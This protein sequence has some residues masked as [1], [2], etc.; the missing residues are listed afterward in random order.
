[1]SYSNDIRRLA[2]QYVIV[3]KYSLSDTC[4]HLKISLPTLKTWLRLNEQGLLYKRKPRSH[5]GRKIDDDAL[6]AY[7]SEHP[8]HYLGEIACVFNVSI[9]GIHAA[10]KRL[11]IRFK[12]NTLL[13]RAGRRKTSHLS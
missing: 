8:D 5:R 13:R 1:M 6:R 7:V 10:L 3:D 11:G 12:K 2:I 4:M 9:S